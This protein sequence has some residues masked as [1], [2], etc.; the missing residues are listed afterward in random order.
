MAAGITLKA[1]ND[2]LTRL[3]YAERLAKANNYFLFT[4]GT[5]DE[6]LD[7]T[8]A[9]RTISRMTLKERVAEF[10]RLKD[11]NEQIIGTAKK[12]AKSVPTQKG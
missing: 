11:L 8:V 4:G 1:V 5:A 6:W 9:V 12:T 2:E 10:Q 3:G 7:R